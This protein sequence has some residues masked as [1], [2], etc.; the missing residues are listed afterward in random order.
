MATEEPK[1]GGESVMAELLETI[2]DLAAGYR[3]LGIVPKRH[4]QHEYID[5]PPA[6]DEHLLWM[7][8]EIPNLIR[9]GKTAKVLRWIGFVQGLLLV[10]EEPIVRVFDELAEKPMHLEYS[11]I[12]REEKKA[13]ILGKVSLYA[14]LLSAS[15]V[16]SKALPI[17]KGSFSWY[18]ALSYAKYLASEEIPRLIGMNDWPKAMYLFGECQGILVGDGIRKISNVRGDNR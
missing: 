9:S 18:E 15:E 12:T 11:G 3:K 8:E 14:N 5:T 16:A 10:R 2:S 6:A 4:N 17:G 13:R 7:L 1:E